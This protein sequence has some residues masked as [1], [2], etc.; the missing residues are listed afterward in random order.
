MVGDEFNNVVEE[1]VFAQGTADLLVG[2][3]FVCGYYV[4]SGELEVGEFALTP[5]HAEVLHEPAPGALAALERGIGVDAL[6]D[7]DNGR[8]AYR[9]SLGHALDALL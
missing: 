4:V 8:S 5:A 2:Q 6:D 7:L 3:R 9:M 1:V